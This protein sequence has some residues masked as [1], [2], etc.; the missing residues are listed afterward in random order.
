MSKI[1]FKN[2]ENQQKL[3]GILH[4]AVN[5]ELLKRIEK[6]RHEK[7][8][9]IFIVDAALI[10][11]SGSYKY[12]HESGAYIILLTSL[13]SIRIERALCRGNLSENQLKNVWIY[14]GMMIKRKIMQTI[15]LRIMTL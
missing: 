3:N 4:P 1:V 5:V 6:I 2:K 11:E 12:Y 7:K 14:N 15:F 13:K 10:I 8:H 9:T